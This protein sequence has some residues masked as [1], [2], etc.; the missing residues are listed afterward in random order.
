VNKSIISLEGASSKTS[1][2][3][4]GGWYGMMP[5]TS[6]SPNAL[7]GDATSGKPVA[8]SLHR[9]HTHTITDNHSNTCAPTCTRLAREEQSKRGR[10][11]SIF[12]CSYMRILKSLLFCHQSVTFACVTRHAQRCKSIFPFRLRTLMRTVDRNILVIQTTYQICML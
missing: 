10:L 9:H 1:L 6:S 3:R 8:F 2:G 7:L 4:L 12:E 11:F 5:T